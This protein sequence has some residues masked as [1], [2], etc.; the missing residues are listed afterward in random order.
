MNFIATSITEL[1]TF[2]VQNQQIDL[3]LTMKCRSKVKYERIFNSLSVSSYTLAILF[4]ALKPIVKKLF[5]I[6]MSIDSWNRNRKNIGHRKLPQTNLRKDL[7]GIMKQVFV[8]LWHL[9]FWRRRFFTSCSENIR[10]FG[11]SWT[12]LK[13]DTPRHIPAQNQLPRCYSFWEDLYRKVDAGR[14]RRLVRDALT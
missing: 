10:N 12:N 14:V 4:F 6:K 8:H 13:E 3:G 11:T 1:Q 7:L 2:K 5:S 9:R